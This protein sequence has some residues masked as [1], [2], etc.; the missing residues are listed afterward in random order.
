ME[1]AR[2]AAAELGIHNPEQPH[3]WIEVFLPGDGPGCK[4]FN[5]LA[6]KCSEFM[7]G[8]KNLKA[9]SPTG[10]EWPVHHHQVS[11]SSAR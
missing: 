6:A 3:G 11:Q 4:S 8:V 9:S 2:G 10:R 1:A 5:L 7:Q